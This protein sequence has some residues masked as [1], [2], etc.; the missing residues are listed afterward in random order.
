MNGCCAFNCNCTRGGSLSDAG[1]TLIPAT[2]AV[3]RSRELSAEDGA[4]SEAVSETWGVEMFDAVSE[5]APLS[6]TG[7]RSRWGP[8]TPT[9]NPIASKSAALHAGRGEIQLAGRNAP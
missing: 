7:P 9:E 3:C 1:N 8:N 4:S 5:S 2:L 6:A